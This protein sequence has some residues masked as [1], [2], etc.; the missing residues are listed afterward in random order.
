MLVQKPK[1]GGSGLLD[2]SCKVSLIIVVVLWHI[3][4]LFISSVNIETL[5]QKVSAIVQMLLKLAGLTQFCIMLW[6]LPLPEGV[7]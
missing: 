1:G 4:S 3:L 2:A 5:K 6:V 7:V